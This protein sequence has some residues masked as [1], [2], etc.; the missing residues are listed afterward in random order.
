M[1]FGRYLA[2]MA[3]TWAIAAA[4]V[5]GFNLLIDPMGISPLR[6]AI[7]GFNERKPLRADYDRIVKRHDVR[8]SQP[9]TI[10]MGSSRIKQTIDPK[11]VTS[12]PFTPAY[13]G[14][15]NGSADYGEIGSYLGYY[16]R[17][18]KK[19]HYVFIEAFAT[20]LLTTPAGPTTQFGLTDDIADFTSVF[21]S[22]GGLSSAIQTVWLNRRNP[23][24]ATSSE[25]GF[26][27]IA[28]PQHHFSVRNVFNFVL[29]TGVINR[30]SRFDLRV[31]VAAKAMLADCKSHGVECRF[32][33]S[34]LHADALYAAYYLGLWPELEKLKRTL[35]ELAPTYDFTRYNDIIEER[36]GP[37][38]YWPE[39]FHF[40]PAL[41]ALMTKAMMGKRAA[42][43]PA[44]FGVLVDKNNIDSGLATCREERDRWIAQHPDAVA[45]MQKAEE[46]FRQGLSFKAVTDAEIAI[47]SW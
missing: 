25:D 24:L 2:V 41:G 15:M 29:H 7:A 40:A 5:G 14:A 28:F 38:V 21:F 31:A 1:R 11:L 13:N 33:I 22:V 19:F 23:R 6:I 43:M 35:A 16:L 20:A 26:A 18:D 9:V 17:V 44:N 36:V 42:D 34:P 4:A 30:A 37:V 12:P 27:A 8:R 32:F 3:A 46:N 10:F 39:A 45:R 47:G